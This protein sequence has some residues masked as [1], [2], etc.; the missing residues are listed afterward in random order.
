[1]GLFSVGVADEP[2]LLSSVD[3]SDDDES[4]LGGRKSD[5]GESALSSVDPSDDD[6]S[7]LGGRKS[8]GGE[9]ALSSRPTV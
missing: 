8:D 3:P 1:M 7:T 2:A 6:E 4:T 5:G 9:S